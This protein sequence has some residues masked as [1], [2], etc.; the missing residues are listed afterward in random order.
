MG[1]ERLKKQLDKE[2]QSVKFSLQEEVM[3]KARRPSFPQRLSALLNK[4]VEIPLLSAGIVVALF[5]SWG[6]KDMIPDEKQPDG[7]A[8]R[9]L[10]EAGGNTYWKDLY[11]KAA[12]KN[13]N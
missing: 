13:E 12:G 9:E 6:I 1:K 11:E 4:E 8:E 3:K 5:F 2:L 10:I 7:Y